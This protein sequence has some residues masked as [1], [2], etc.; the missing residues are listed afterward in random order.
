ML[1]YIVFLIIFVGVTGALYQVYETHYNINVGNDKKLSNANKSRLKELSAKAI[2]AT[3]TNASSA[4]DHAVS[5]A[6]GPEFDRGVALTAFTQAEEGS[7]AIPLLRRKAQLRFNGDND[8]VTVRHLPFWQTQLPRINSRAVLVALV[9]VNCFLV[10]LLGA[11]SIYTLNY[12][13]SLPWLAWLN[14]PLVVMLLI[15]ALL[16]ISFMIAKLD[17]Y[18]H[19]L[20]QLGALFR[21]EAVGEPEFNQ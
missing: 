2:T 17:R 3:Q 15:Y 19:D 21:H 4:F 11:M 20:Y 10:Q 9:I 7:Y 1:I 8:A 16:F 12:P 14:E 5:N 18:M 6:L 13:V